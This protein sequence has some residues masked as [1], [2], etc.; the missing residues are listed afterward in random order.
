MKNDTLKD[1]YILIPVTCEYYLTTEKNKTKQK[2]NKQQQQQNKK[3]PKTQG[4]RCDLIKYLVWGDYPGS[5]WIMPSHYPYKTGTEGDFTHIVEK[6]MW[7]M[8]HRET[9][10]CWP[11]RLE[12]WH[13]RNGKIQGLDSPV[14]PL[15]EGGPS[16]TVILVKR[17]RFGTSGFQNCEIIN[18]I[19]FGYFK[20]SSW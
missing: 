20:P 18:A 2:H 16:H 17:Y 3:L 10:R 7:K 11:W 13:V 19:H 4:F 8:G 6:A 5:S 1:I 15:R 12:W 9:Y 14:E